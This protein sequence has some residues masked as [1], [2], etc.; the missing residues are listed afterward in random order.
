VF[1]GRLSNCSWAEYARLVEGALRHCGILLAR[2]TLKGAFRRVGVVQLGQ[3]QAHS[4][5][6]ASLD[7]LGVEVVVAQLLRLFAVCSS[8]RR[9]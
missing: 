8:A 9:R 6:M 2:E 7:I 1:R 4:S 3:R 5:S